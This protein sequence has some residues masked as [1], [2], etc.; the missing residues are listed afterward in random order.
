ML[1]DQFII[2][3]GGRGTRLNHPDLPKVLAPLKG[4]PLISYLLGQI[5]KIARNQKPII[6]VGFMANKVKAS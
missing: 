3:A 4:R 6:V 5:G 1:K 2:L